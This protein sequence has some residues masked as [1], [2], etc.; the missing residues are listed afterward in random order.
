MQIQQEGGLQR[1]IERGRLSPQGP[2][3]DPGPGHS[4]MAKGLNPAPELPPGGAM[5]SNVRKKSNGL[6]IGLSGKELDFAKP[7]WKVWRVQP[8]RS[9]SQGLGYQ[10][11]RSAS[12]LDRITPN[13]QAG[14]VG[15]AIPR[16]A[17]AATF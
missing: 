3:D 2:E 12:S 11:S 17:I 5:H 13:V 8:S 6:G 10:S 14:P 16:V 15:G 4:C 7:S 9:P 1:V